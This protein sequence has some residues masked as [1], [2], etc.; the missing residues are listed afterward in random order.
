[1]TASPAPTTDY[2]AS[3]HIDAPAR[4]VF[5]ALTTTKGLA[6]WWN[7]AAG[8]GVAGGELRFIM[9]APEPLVIRVD[10]ATAPT[11]VRWTVT[12]C[13]F[14]EDWIGTQPHFTITATGVGSCE[15]HFR[16]YGLNPGLDCFD[17]CQLSWN[18]YMASLRAYAERG[19]G[20]PF[21]SPGDLVRRQAQAL[22]A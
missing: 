2:T 1:M 21:G 14:L 3:V 8:S 9:N 10:E 12:D 19:V 18:H 5:A 11:T 13:P 16:H 4:T 20:S 17:M 6:G 7:P 22:R 15:V